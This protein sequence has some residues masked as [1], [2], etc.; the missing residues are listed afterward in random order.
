MSARVHIAVTVDDKYSK[1]APAFMHS[2][3]ARTQ[4]AVSFHYID[5]GLSSGARDRIANA[6]ARIKNASV[7]FVSIDADRL[8]EFPARDRFPVSVYYRLF[9]GTAL[10]DLDKVLFLDVDISARGDIGELYDID[11]GDKIVAAVEDGGQLSFISRLKRGMEIAVAAKYFNSGVLLISLNKW[12][13]ARIEERVFDI[14]KEYKDRMFCYDQDVLNKIFSEDVLW[15]PRRFNS[16]TADEGVVLRHFYLGCKPWDLAEALCEGV[17]ADLKLFW[18]DV[19]EIGDYD[20]I[21]KMVK[22]RTP[23]QQR[24]LQIA[25]KRVGGVSQNECGQ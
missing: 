13:L 25:F 4:R 12:R 22:Y 16:L 18:D 3:C 7:R 10:P 24:M 1:Y 21:A 15:L 2:I 19:R 5:G 17:F 8:K 23:L 9:L 14:V 6:G 11:L 20:E